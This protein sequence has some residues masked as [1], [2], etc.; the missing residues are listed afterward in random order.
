[1]DGEGTGRKGRWLVDDGWWMVDSACMEQRRSDATVRY[2]PRETR[3]SSTSSWPYDAAAC[4]CESNDD[5]SEPGAQC[6]V[7]REKQC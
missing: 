5:V 2:A 3:Y 1:M 7:G 4:L 6:R